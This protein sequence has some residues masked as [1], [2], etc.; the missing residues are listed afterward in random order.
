MSFVYYDFAQNNQY[1]QLSMDN[2]EYIYQIFSVGIIKHY[3]M[4]VLPTREYTKDE[5]K[6]TIKL[7]KDNSIYD[8]NVKVN[9]KDK[10]L[11]LITCTR[12]YGASADVDF[13]VSAKLV[14]NTNSLKLVKIKKNKKYDKIETI[15]KGDDSDAQI[16]A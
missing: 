10:L 5:L 14:K 1:I 16:T 11:S 3:Y 13:V 8:Y 9:E 12:M 7:Y 2:K 6:N 15:M 4:S